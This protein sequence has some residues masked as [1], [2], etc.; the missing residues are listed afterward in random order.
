[1]T[2][3]FT[4]GGTRAHTPDLDW[5]QVRET[6]L[7]LE[8]AAGQIEAALKDSNTSVDV[9]MD[10]FTTMAGYLHTITNV[11]D[12]LPDEGEVGNTKHN[13]LGVAEHVTGM[14]QQSIIAFQ[15]YDKLTQRLSHVCHSLASLTDLVGNH[16]R[17]YNPSEWV[18][19]QEQIRS[20]YSTTEERA[21]FEAVMSGVPVHEALSRFMSEMKVKGNDV[22]LF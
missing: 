2:G 18:A 3:E 10:S 9:L 13:L 11:L 16:G 15:F 20:K 22:E 4:K 19:L 5:S 14:A 8:L 1:M 17:I 12:S 21:M 6:M 7:M